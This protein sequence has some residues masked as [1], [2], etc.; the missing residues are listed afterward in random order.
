MRHVGRVLF[1]VAALAGQ[2]LSQISHDLPVV[3]SGEMP[4]YP[5]LPRLALLESEVR[6]RVTT[7]GARAVSVAIESGHPMLAQAAVDNVMTWRFEKHEPTS[8]ET[9]FSYSVIKHFSC[10]PGKP[11]SPRVLLELPSRVEVTASAHLQEDGDP[12]SGLDLSEPLR[13]FLTACELDGALI[14]CDLVKIE[15]RSGS[16]TIVPETFRESAEKQGFVVPKEFRAVKSFD[17]TVDIRGKTFTAADVHADFLKGKW[18]VG[19]D[20]RPFKDH[21]PVYGLPDT[22]TCVAFVHFQWSEPERVVWAPC[23]ETK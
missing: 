4:L 18:R 23:K 8:F 9:Q 5:R 7:D 22:V 16:T 19:I 1:V 14:P 13:V 6:L 17:V 21:T 2:L 20:H 11:G 3:T 12:N 15:L 10:S